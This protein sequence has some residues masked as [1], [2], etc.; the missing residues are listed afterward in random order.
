MEVSYTTLTQVEKLD[1][2]VV[3]FLFMAS[4]YRCDNLIT[5]LF[6]FLILSTHELPFRLY[7]IITNDYQKTLHIFFN[8]I[9]ILKNIFL[10]GYSIWVIYG[11]S[12]IHTYTKEQAPK[13][14]NLDWHLPYKQHTLRAGFFLEIAAGGL[15]LITSLLFIL[16]VM[17]SN[18][19]DTS[20]VNPAKN[21]R[22]VSST[23]SRN[24]ECRC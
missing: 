2:L 22:S 10:Y 17:I 16:D 18:R 1:L 19:Q 15:F 13:D 14:L 20:S 8:L 6:L 11:S 23:Q 3:D 12:F 21:E 9:N 5:L 7:R 4:S 24:H